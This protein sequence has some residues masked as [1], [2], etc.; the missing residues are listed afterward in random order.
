MNVKMEH[1]RSLSVEI[2]EAGQDAEPAAIVSC[3]DFWGP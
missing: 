1:H 2:S 3:L